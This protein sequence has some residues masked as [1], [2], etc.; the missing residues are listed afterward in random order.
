[1]KKE[2]NVFLGTLFAI[3]LI[4]LTT[5]CDST[6]TG[7]GGNG[8]GGSPVIDV[9]F[10][11]VIETGGTST[12]TDSTGLTL[13]FD[14]DP[15]TLTAANITVTGAAKGALSGSGTTRSLAISGITVDDG[16]TVS[17]TITSPS[18]YLISGSPNTAAVY[19]KI[20]ALRDTGQAGGL[21]FHDKGSYSDGWRY[22]EAAP[23][24]TEWTDKQWGKHGTDLG[25]Y[26]E[27]IGTGKNN[28]ALIVAGLNAEP[29]DSDR[30]AQLCDALI[31]EG[32]NDW[33]LPSRDELNAMCWVLHSRSWNGS[34]T[35]NNPAYGDSR[36]GNFS[37]AAYLSSSESWGDEVHAQNFTNGFQ[38]NYCSKN[39]G[40][41]VRAVRAF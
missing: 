1:M 35:E 17:V 21:I 24:S 3:L 32:Y 41:Y 20:Y 13:T 26:D 37:D 36:V 8:G 23:Q 9:V 39:N 18:G 33:F 4:L 22:L 30:A 12:T 19:R 6:G 29:A 40:L 2:R 7:V 14:V 15:T 27:G 10:Q 25:V 16:E 11:S 38:Y 34:A 31:H 28:T 5:G